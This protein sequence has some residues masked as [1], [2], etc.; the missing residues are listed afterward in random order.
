MAILHGSPTCTIPTRSRSSTIVS[1]QLVQILLLLLSMQIQS[2]FDVIWNNH[3]NNNQHNNN[4]NGSDP[5][6][7]NRRTNWNLAFAT[8]PK[9]IVVAQSVEDVVN[10]VKN[11]TACPSP[12]LAVGS[13]KSV[14]S[15]I[16]NDGGTLLNLASMTSILEYHPATGMVTCDAGVTLGDLH[17]YLLTSHQRE[18][19]FS[20]EM[21]DATVGS[22]AVTTS[23]DSSVQGPGSFSAIVVSL[24]YVDAN[25]QVQSLDRDLQPEAFQ[26]FICSFGMM[27]IVVQ[28]Q[29]ET[30]PAAKIL[31]RVA[32]TENVAT[33]EDAYRILQQAINQ[34]DNVFALVIPQEGTMV[35]EERY[36]DIT[37]RRPLFK[38]VLNHFNPVFLRLLQRARFYT[39][40]HGAPF[41]DASLSWTLKKLGILDTVGKQVLSKWSIDVVHYRKDFTNRYDAVTLDQ[42]RL[43]FSL[44]IYDLYDD[45]N[46]IKASD[47]SL[48]S[49]SSASSSPSSAMLEVI[50]KDIWNFVVDW[51]AATGYAPS[52][53]NVYF[54][55]RTGEKPYGE[56]RGPPGLSFA[57]DPYDGDPNSP[58]WRRFLIALNARVLV[59][60]N[61]RMSPTQSRFVQEGDVVL[62]RS[63]V[64][65]RFLTPHYAKFVE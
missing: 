33:A 15:C 16:V 42:H 34:G 60:H 23:K 17:D 27:G 44:Y 2:T 40:Q 47:Y 30:R 14:T 29:L 10:C 4:L 31:T 56:L 24:T 13:M 53:W 49:V 51:H 36:A 41:S 3:H 65:E 57:M 32:A 38:Y 9:T 25:G 19:S 12:V 21:G 1:I 8:Y 64:R 39:I 28:V 63:V 59:L 50:F 43:D 54:M 62:P 45:N 55:H 26:D 58:E 20:P 35:V 6:N 7:P 52:G 46:N 48:S 61:A 11:T 5:S 18:I 37:K 22:L